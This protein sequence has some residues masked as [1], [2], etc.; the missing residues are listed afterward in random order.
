MT[1]VKHNQDLKA[2][3]YHKLC[4]ILKQHQIEVNE[5]RAERLARTA[6]PLALTGQYE[7]QRA[8][9]VVGARDNVGTQDD[10]NDEPMELEAHYM[11]IAKIQEVI[12]DA[13]DNY[14]PI[15]DTEP[16]EKVH[17]I[18][19]NYNVFSNARKHH[20]QHESI[21][22]TYVMEKDD[23]N[24]SLDSSDMCNDEREAGQDDEQA[25][26]HDLLAS[27]IEQMK[28]KIDENKN[29]NKYTEFECAK[30]YGL[31][32]EQK[33]KSE[34]SFNAYTLKIHELNQKL[35]KMEREVC[36]NQSTISIIS[37]EKEKHE[38]FYK[39]R[40]DKEIERVICLENQVKYL[41]DIVY[42]TGQSIQTMNMLNRN[43]KKSFV[44]PQYLKKDQSVNLRLFDIGCYNDNLALMLAPKTNE[45]IRL[46][47][48][49]QSK[50]RIANCFN[51][52][53]GT[54]ENIPVSPEMKNVIEQKLSPTVDH[55]A[56][57]VVESYQTLKEEMVADLRYLHSLKKEV[58]Y[59]QSQLELQQTKFS[60]EIDRLCR[61]YFYADHMNAILGY[62]TN[63]D[64]Y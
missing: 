38:K 31:L 19:D 57:D 11:Y 36:A 21:N 34:K 24:I 43:C 44:K 26:E 59:L 46:A 22:D 10:T 53:N 47:R 50:L 5:I 32:E 33:V 35:S 2:V 12:P 18:D 58:E 30:A 61:E 9:N 52:M 45:M 41:N 14:G 42:K 40:T 54:I 25:K 63:L 37:F 55:I 62:Y 27:L 49:S 20:E 4:D 8:V 17:S 3:S 1:I 51:I 48:E 29:Q 7:N 28:F 56:T 16:L 64:E 39:T 13:A 15:F 60:N 23:I 6:N